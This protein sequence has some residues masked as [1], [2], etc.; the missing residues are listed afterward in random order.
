MRPTQTI[1]VPTDMSPRSEAA[2]EHAAALADQYGARL[3]IVHVEE[4]PLAAYGEG[5]FEYAMPSTDQTEVRKEFE[6]IR[7]AKP[8]VRYQH[9]WLR[10]NPV[11]QIT[12]LAKEENVDL[13]VLSSHGRTGLI[14]LVMGSVAEGVMRHAECPVLVI[15]T[16]AAAAAE[17][18]G[19]AK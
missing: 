18:A 4:P 11:E 12:G 16:P 3:L 10:G 17:P 9:F 5:H 1:L 2:F 19:S 13:I 15:K 7:P 6:Q 8:T 14:R